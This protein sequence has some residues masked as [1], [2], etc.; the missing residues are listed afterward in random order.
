M[1]RVLL[2]EDEDAYR[3]TVGYLL[4]KEG[5]DVVEAADGTIGLAEF[6]RGGA[7]IVLLDDRDAAIERFNSRDDD[8]EWTRHNNELVADLGGDEF[9]ASMYDRLLSVLDARPD[10]L[11]VRS[12]P[13][14]IDETAA[15]LDRALTTVRAEG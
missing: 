10:A 9:L 2:I 15:A 14:A 3:E 13:G 12:T 4:R 11:V 8:S 5:F 6:E 1:T 7:D